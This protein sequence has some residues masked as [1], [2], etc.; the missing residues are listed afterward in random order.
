MRTAT[1]RHDEII[2]TLV[3]AHNGRVVRP[4]GEGDSRFLV[5]MRQS[6]LFGLHQPAVFANQLG[7][8]DCASKRP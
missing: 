5:F 8:L 6:L 7:A 3:A 2:D 4:R 1:T